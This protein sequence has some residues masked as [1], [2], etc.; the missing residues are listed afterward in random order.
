[1]R[2]KKTEDILTSIIMV[3]TDMFGICFSKIIHLF[4][5]SGYN[6]SENYKSIF[7]KIILHPKINNLEF[8]AIVN[9]RYYEYNCLFFLPGHTS[10]MENFESHLD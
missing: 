10:Q 4:P 6:F 9:I 5:V 8:L 3:L 2:T 1:M 7:Q